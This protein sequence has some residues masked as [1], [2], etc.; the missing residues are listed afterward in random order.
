MQVEVVVKDHFVLIKLVILRTNFFYYYSS[1]WCSVSQSCP[2]HCDPMDC[3]IPG[4]PVP[5]HLSE[6]AHTYVHWVGDAIQPSR[7]L[8]SPSPPAFNLYSLIWG[9]WAGYLIHWASI[10]TCSTWDFTESN[11]WWV[12]PK[13]DLRSLSYTEVNGQQKVMI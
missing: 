4:F 11:T 1:T 8:L 10:S 5:H 2:T 3:S 9:S 12:H 7:P 13:W 6:L